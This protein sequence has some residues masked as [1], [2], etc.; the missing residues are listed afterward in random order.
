MSGKDR[1]KQLA[2][3]HY[4]R[5]LQRRA[6]REAKAKRT[7]IIGSSV[8]TVVVVAGIIT[9]TALLGGSG[10]PASTE[11]AA[12]PSASTAEPT[13]FDAA[14]GTCGYV[15]A[16]ESGQVKDV[17]MPPAKVDTS[18][19][20]MTLKTSQGDIVIEVNAGKTPCTVG[21]FAFLASKDYFDGSK[22][23]RLGSE[24]FP[25]LQCGDPLAKADGTSQTDGQ[26]GP[27]YRF[28]NE[29]LTGAKYTRGVVAMANSGPDTN[30]SQFFIVYG[31]A[32]LPANY[33]PFGTVT[34]GLE[35]VDKVNKAG[36]ITPGPD[37][38]GAPK[39]TVEIKDVTMSATS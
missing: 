6:E 34:K 1:Q 20:S 7:A 13:A 18:P 9:A 19:K 35:I 27:G 28:V 11:A 16:A 4:E 5:Q 15:P 29:N 32:G 30:G 37:G 8:G 22:C 14:T 23:H 33:T 10:D 31:D 26:G 25:V 12:T 21:S 36:V 39:K 3:E 2:R 38:T 17:G 24:Q